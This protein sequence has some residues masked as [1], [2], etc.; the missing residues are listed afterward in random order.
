MPRTSVHT[1]TGQSSTL[2]TTSVLTLTIIAVIG[3]SAAIASAQ[4]KPNFSGAWKMNREKSK[5]DG[6]DAPTGITLKIDQKGADL[7]ETIDVQESGGDE[8]VDGKYVIDGKESD[9]QLG[10]NIAKGTA[11][12]EGDTLVI[13]WKADGFNFQRKYFLSADGKTITMAVRRPSQ[14]GEVNETVVLEK[15]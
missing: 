12:W 7:V 11:R 5:F 10:P 2:K 1:T 3:L 13:E 6:T 15:Q 9:I 8:A 14:N 4:T